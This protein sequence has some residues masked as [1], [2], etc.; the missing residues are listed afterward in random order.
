[1]HFP[2]FSCTKTRKAD[3]QNPPLKKLSVKSFSV[4]ARGESPEYGTSLALVAW[5]TC[6]M[7]GGPLLILQLFEGATD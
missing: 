2:P 1:M 7:N 5:G 6:K 3:T 4:T